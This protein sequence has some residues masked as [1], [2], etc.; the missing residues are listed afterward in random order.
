MCRLVCPFVDRKPQR[1]VFSSQGK[2][3]AQR[4]KTCPWRF[5]SAQFDQRLCYSLTGKYHISTCFKQN[6]NFLASLCSWR[7]WFETSF[8]RHQEDRF[9]RDEAQMVCYFFP[10]F[11]HFMLMCCC[12]FVV[13]IMK[14]LFWLNF[15][16]FPF[17]LAVFNQTYSHTWIT[18]NMH[19]V[20]VL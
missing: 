19:M 2:N 14:S 11:V 20:A 5:A 9:S 15:K 6:F 10:Q 1:Q 13:A 3:G 4:E 18:L 17:V 8:V 12:Y 7:D 16:G